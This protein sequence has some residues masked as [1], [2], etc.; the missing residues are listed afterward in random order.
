MKGLL[1]STITASILISGCGGGK[2]SPFSYNSVSNI[3]G[4]VLKGIA[5]D[6]VICQP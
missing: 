5:I 2:G 4:N 6:G 1:L 3:E